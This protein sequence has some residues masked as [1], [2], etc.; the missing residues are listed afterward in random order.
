MERGY[1]YLKI[2]LKKRGDALLE[3]IVDSANAWRSAA[4]VAKKSAPTSTISITTEQES[5]L[6]VE[7]SAIKNK[8]VTFSPSPHSHYWSEIIDHPEFSAAAWDSIT[9]KPSTFPPSAHSHA[10]S[11]VAGLS[12]ALSGKEPV[13]SSGG[14]GTYWRWDKTWQTLNTEAVP[15]STNLYYT[16]ARVDARITSTWRGVASGLASL[17]TDGKVPLSQLPATT[18]VEVY[19]AASESAM[20]AL[21]AQQGDVCV[22][23]D[24]STTYILKASPASTLSNWQMILT[25]TDGVS[26][27]GLSLPS[28]F[29]VSGS[30]VTSTGTLTAVLA[31]QTANTFLS[32][33]NG[34]T[35][36]PS[37]RVIV[38][39]DLP[40]ATASVRGAVI[41][42]AGLT[43]SSGTIAVAYGNTAGTAAQG[44]DPRLSDAR[45]PT[46]HALDGALHTISG[47]TAGQLLLATS[48]TTFGFATLSGDATLSGAGALTLAASG[49]T[50]GSYGGAANALVLSVDAKGRI[51]SASTVAITPAGIGALGLTAQAA[52]SAKLGGVLASAFAL[53]AT[54]AYTG[55]GAVDPNTLTGLQSGF[56]QATAANRPGNYAFVQTLA[57]Y[58]GGSLQLAADSYSSDTQGLW[59]RRKGDNGTWYPWKTIW[60]SGNLTPAAIGALPTSV[61]SSLTSLRV[62]YWD[63]SKLVDSPIFNNTANYVCETNFLATGTVTAQGGFQSSSSSMNSLGNILCSSIQAMSGWGTGV[64]RG[65]TLSTAEGSL[66]TYPIASTSGALYGSAVTTPDGANYSLRWT[67]DGAYALL[68]GTTESILAIN[69]SWVVKATATGA[70]INSPWFPVQATNP[71]TIANSGRWHFTGVATCSLGAP[72]AGRMVFLTRTIGSYT[73]TLTTPSGIIIW[74]A[75]VGGI[76]AAGSG[77]SMAYGY[78][79]IVLMADGTNWCAC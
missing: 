61:T 6:V 7:W 67:T 78:G 77:A 65:A 59:W 25:P 46:A 22:R 38:G 51:T 40:V 49:V 39:A 70:Q 53:E 52:D 48:A 62:P 42:G 69:G 54:I 76:A 10:I 8:P 27:V 19:T 13:I 2:Q 56:T 71:T 29:T 9:G 57:R 79:G 32:A 34:A 35:G 20:L 41:P 5:D 24:T 30:P 16:D 12:D 60:H 4:T 33:P 66:R 45:T 68:N 26:S 63:G 23:T 15:E 50:A 44:N 58:N 74:S 37:F 11:D 18:I 14:V 28:I 36:A 43:V 17:G 64:V 55:T 1:E 73:V 3:D 75:G 72:T 21:T 47:K 31:S